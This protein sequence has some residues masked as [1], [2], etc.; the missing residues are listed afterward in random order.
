M[1]SFL[2]CGGA[3]DRGSMANET[4]GLSPLYPAVP[5]LSV[6]SIILTLLLLPGF[7]KIGV[8]AVISYAGWLLIGNLLILINMSVWRGNT[9]HPGIYGDIV[10]RF[11]SVYSVGLYLNA[12]CFHKFIW[13]LSGT[14]YRVKIYKQRKRTNIIDGFICILLPLMWVPLSIFS[15]YSRFSVIEDLGPFPT[16]NFDL[17]TFILYVM[18][19]FLI[20]A[21]SAVMTILSTKNFWRAHRPSLNPLHRPIPAGRMYKYL[22]LFFTGIGFM[23]YGAAWSVLAFARTEITPQWTWLYFTPLS[24]SLVNLKRVIYVNRLLI[25]TE[26]WDVLNVTGFLIS[27]PCCGIHLFA[28]FGLGEETREGYIN[29]S[30]ILLRLLSRAL[31]CLHLHKWA[32]VVSRAAEPIQ[33]PNSAPE[34]VD[35]GQGSAPQ[36]EPA[37]EPEEIPMPALEP[38]VERPV[39]HIHTNFSWSPAR[40]FLPPPPSIS[41]PRAPPSAYPRSC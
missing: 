9:K 17:A 26:A 27:V 32:S 36:Q 19:L 11:W 13:N 7:I 8:L 10:S 14:S 24:Q 28:F 18:P 39:L 34:G 40:Q 2:R 3:R 33:N 15:S 25:D 22:L 30:K 4:L 20:T 31:Y 37:L 35:N 23:A 6:A 16:H 38:P 29:G 12:F 41:P 21:A 1:P 5:V